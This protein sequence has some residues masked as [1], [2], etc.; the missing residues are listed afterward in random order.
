MLIKTNFNEVGRTGDKWTGDCMTIMSSRAEGIKK[1]RIEE[2]KQTLGTC[3]YRIIAR[4]TNS[5]GKLP[6]MSYQSV[7]Q[8]LLK[9]IY[10]VP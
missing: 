10:L 3:R 9:T 7:S 4:K 6:D 1:N 5:L 2:K 8:V